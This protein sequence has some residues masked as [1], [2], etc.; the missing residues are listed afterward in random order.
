MLIH[1]LQPIGDFVVACGWFDDLLRPIGDCCGVSVLWS[2]R[3]FRYSGHMRLLWQTE[4][5]NKSENSFVFK[6]ISEFSGDISVAKWY[7]LW[8]FCCDKFSS[9]TTVGN[10]WDNDSQLVT[11]MWQTF[12]GETNVAN[13]WYSLLL[14]ILLRQ[15]QRGNYWVK[16][17]IG[18]FMRQVR[19]GNYWGK[20]YIGDST[21]TSSAGNYWGKLYIGDF[22]ET[23]SAGNY[24]GKLYIDHCSK[25]VMLLWPVCRWYYHYVCCWY[26]SGQ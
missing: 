21:E 19:R 16:I 26:F 24:W 5:Q 3:Y 6:I 20:L 25:I 17:Y 13:L 1:R 11:L 8:R 10:L 15:V 14:V 9:K 18:D 12:S 7:A 2:F 4:W 23:S 22:T